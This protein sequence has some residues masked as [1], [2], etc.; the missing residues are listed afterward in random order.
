MESTRSRVAVPCLQESSTWA[1]REESLTLIGER[2]AA[3]LPTAEAPVQAAAADVP[4]T[5]GVAVISLRGLITARPSLVSLLFGGGGGLRQFRACLREA[6]ASEEIGSILLDIDSPGGSTDL[7]P[8]VADEIRGYRGTKPI[9]AI[10]NTMAASGAYWLASAA[11]EIVV[12]PS[13]M[14]GSIGVF[15]IHSDWTGYNEQLGVKPT[16]IAAGKYKVEGNE[17]EALS[18]EAFQARKEIVDD[19]YELFIAGVAAGRG[20]TANVVR[21]GFGEGRVVTAKRAVEL[22]MA[23]R[24]ESFEGT[25]SKLAGTGATS[26][27][28]GALRVS[29]EGDATEFHAASQPTSKP[30]E[31]QPIDKPEPKAGAE[32]ERARIARLAT[33]KPKH[34]NER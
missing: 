19:F 3:Q 32:E 25:V 12:T 26:A 9:I 20:V 6:V 8:E 2:L 1:V 7:M 17:N 4:V 34:K 5:G 16:Y 23:D 13:G 14:V 21:S 29:L 27:K 18:E 15:L 31:E 10:S 28:T 11:D 22:G 30:N 24:V 33:Q